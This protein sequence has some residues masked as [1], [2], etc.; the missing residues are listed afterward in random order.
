MV[1]YDFYKIILYLAAFYFLNQFISIFQTA[2]YGDFNLSV[3]IWDNRFFYTISS[4][5]SSKFDF[6]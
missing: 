2:D 3:S 1:T 5:D 6:V 4:P